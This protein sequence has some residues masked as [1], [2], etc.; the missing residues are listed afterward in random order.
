M[1]YDDYHSDLIHVEQKEYYLIYRY[2]SN[3][4]Y[5]NNITSDMSY[6]DACLVTDELIDKIMFD[7]PEK[8]NIDTNYFYKYLN[9]YCNSIDMDTDC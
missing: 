3:I 5:K 7:V 1:Q 8:Y 4:Y 6:E 9:A 2:I